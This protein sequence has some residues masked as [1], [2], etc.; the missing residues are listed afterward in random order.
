MPSNH[1]AGIHKP[2]VT[3]TKLQHKKPTHQLQK[4]TNAVVI[5]EIKKS[6]TSNVNGR[7]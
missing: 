2:N 1:L 7:H 3:A 5:C 6:E 4:K